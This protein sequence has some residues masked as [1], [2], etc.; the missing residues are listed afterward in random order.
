MRGLPAGDLCAVGDREIGDRY[1]Y[2]YAS[3]RAVVFFFLTVVF[4]FLGVA[5]VPVV[6]EAEP[7]RHQVTG[8]GHGEVLVL[9]HILHV[10]IVCCCYV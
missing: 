4:F 5:P 6:G 2:S 3:K 10:N 1:C 7:G 8:T 9:V